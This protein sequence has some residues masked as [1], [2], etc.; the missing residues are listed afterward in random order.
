MAVAWQP[1]HPVP[2]QAPAPLSYPAY[3]AVTPPSYYLP[4]P[5]A[6]YTPGYVAGVYAQAGAPSERQDA[7]DR[8]QAFRAENAARELE[9]DRRSA[10]NTA[11]AQ[12]RAAFVD[13]HCHRIHNDL[14]VLVADRQQRETFHESFPVEQPPPR[15]PPAGYYAPPLPPPPA[16]PSALLCKAPPPPS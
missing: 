4:G 1:G 13:S 2:Y 10:H 7:L 9:A 14:S 16:P 5:A 6:A 12:G 3:A 8:L 11:V 15:Y